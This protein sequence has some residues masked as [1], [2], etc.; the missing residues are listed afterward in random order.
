[1]HDDPLVFTACDR[2]SRILMFLMLATVI[3]AQ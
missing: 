1:M 2:T 3:L